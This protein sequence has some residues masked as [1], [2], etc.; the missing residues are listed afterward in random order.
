IEQF[1]AQPPDRVVFGYA[2]G[3]HEKEYTSSTGALWRWMSERG[4]LRARGNGR[5]LV[6]SLAGA[7]ESFSRPSHVTVRVGDR[8]V[9][10]QEAGKEFT[11]RA[12]I[13]S[14][15]FGQDG[16]GEAIIT[17]ETDQAYVPAE[18]SSRTAD[19]RHLG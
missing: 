6:L 4:V 19:R 15:L 7:T 18:H 3:W 2:E 11:I 8:I 10:Q 5:P 9:A 16:R 12:E 1:D 17:I 14:D 13:P